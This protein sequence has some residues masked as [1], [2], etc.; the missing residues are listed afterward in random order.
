[1]GKI[2]RHGTFSP[3]EFHAEQEYR[4]GFFPAGGPENGLLPVPNQA[5]YLFDDLV[6]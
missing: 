6:R 5:Q 1:M 2:K 3:S 4:R